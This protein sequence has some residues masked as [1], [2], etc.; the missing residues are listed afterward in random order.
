ML[1]AG[2]ATLQFVAGTHDVSRIA[3][4]VRRDGNTRMLG[5]ADQQLLLQGLMDCLE[6]PATLQHR[7]LPI[8][9]GNRRY[10]WVLSL[11]DPSASVWVSPG[12]EGRVVTILDAGG[13]EIVVL[14]ISTA[15]EA[16]W[17]H[18]IVRR[19]ARFELPAGS[20]ELCFV[21]RNKRGWTEIWLRRAGELRLLGADSGA[22]IR[23]R[24]LAGLQAPES[25]S[26]QPE[27]FGAASRWG[28]WFLSLTA[29]HATFWAAESPRGR[30]ITIVDREGHPQFVFTLSPAEADVWRCRLSD[31]PDSAAVAG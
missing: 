15:E 8:M 12:A 3:V 28:W 11:T 24:L 30:E 4:Y 31:S 23:E 2:S 1:G 29:P 19:I 9:G 14:N 27:R 17:L 20:S 26:Q 16:E 7:C 25:F 10:W 13:Q 18:S 5:V 22:L 21:V 6:S